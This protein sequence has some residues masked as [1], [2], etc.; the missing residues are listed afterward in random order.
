MTKVIK[1]NS[2]YIV[3]M[4]EKYAETSHD[5]SKALQFANKDTALAYI[6]SNSLPDFH[7]EYI[8][9]FGKN[10][11][12]GLFFTELSKNKIKQAI[13]D[14]TI[15]Y[16][17]LTFKYSAYGTIQANPDDSENSFLYKPNHVGTT[18]EVVKYET[19]AK[20]QAAIRAIVLKQLGEKAV[21]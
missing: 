12:A 6:D 1:P 20:I 21:L 18:F 19:K 3:G 13:I 14:G 7:K 5:E 8:V 4:G 10:T 2:K 16:V 11:G 15:G 17:G 9:E